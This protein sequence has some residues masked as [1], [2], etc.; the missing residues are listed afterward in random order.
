MSNVTVNISFQDGLLRDI[1]RIARREDRSRSELLREAARICIQ[2]RDRWSGL[3]AVG[4]AIARDKGLKPDD[5]A[6]EI[7]ALRTS[8]LPLIPMTIWSW[9]VQEPLTWSSLSRAMLTFKSS[10]SGSASELSHLR[11]C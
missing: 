5:V 3:F 1:D 4:R 2:R 10:A 7:L 9:N 8:K 6:R 11:R